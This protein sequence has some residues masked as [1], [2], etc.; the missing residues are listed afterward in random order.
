VDGERWTVDGARWTVN[1]PEGF[2]GPI[3]FSFQAH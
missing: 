2:G 1:S 3:L